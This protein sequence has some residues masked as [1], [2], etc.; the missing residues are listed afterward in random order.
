[1]SVS[2]ETNKSASRRPMP[3]HREFPKPANPD[4]KTQKRKKHL[5][6]HKQGVRKHD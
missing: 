2:P 3:M 4:S 6:A 5:T 1:M